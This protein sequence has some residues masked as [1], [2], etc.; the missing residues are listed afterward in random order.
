MSINAL[1]SALLLVAAT[2]QLA[3]AQ[4]T[5]SKTDT[6]STVAGK[7]A[8]TYE[9]AS[10]GKFELVLNQDSNQKLTGQVIMLPDDG[11]RYPITLKT[12]VWQ[13]GKL[14]ATYIDP[15]ENDEVNFTGSL[16]NATLKG[17][18]QSDGGQATGTWQV[19]RSAAAPTR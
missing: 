5:S 6:S 19:N 14:S 9:G 3:T 16:M 1:F 8:G 12:V 4:T 15:A 10:S 17:T 13:N 7:W 2:F 11:N 18:W